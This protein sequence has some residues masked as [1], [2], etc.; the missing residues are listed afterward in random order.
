MFICQT[1]LNLSCYV[2]CVSQFMYTGLRSPAFDSNRNTV[3]F[4]SSKCSTSSAQV[5]T[6]SHLYFPHFA[7]ILTAFGLIATQVAPTVQRSDVLIPGLPDNLNGFT[8]ALVTDVHIG[9]TVGKDRVEQIVSLV[10]SLNADMIAIAGDLVD[11]FLKNLENRA[12]PLAS[13]NAKHGVF[14]ATEFFIDQCMPSELD[15]KRSKP[16][17]PNLLFQSKVAVQVQISDRCGRKHE[18]YHGSVEEWIKFFNSQLH[19]QKKRHIKH[20][21]QDRLLCVVGLDDLITER[22][23]IAGHKMNPKAAVEGCPPKSIIVVLAHQPNAV[24]KIIDSTNRHIDLI[25]SGHTHNSQFYV[26]W[27]IVYLRNAFLYGLY[28]DSSSGTQVYVSAGVNYWGPPVKMWNNCEIVFISLKAGSKSSIKEFSDVAE[29][30]L[31]AG[32]GGNLPGA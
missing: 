20:M 10:N 30:P 29:P 6:L 16:T 18:Y 3:R 23:F 26:F 1:I 2:S 13:L 28:K 32:I 15:G 22:L 7:L 4:F 14:Y 24:R 8:I 21:D 27:P 9:P 12:L 5:K 17:F 31:I 19:F 25:L 11:G